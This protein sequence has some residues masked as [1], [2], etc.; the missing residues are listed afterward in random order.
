MT[1][2][3]SKPK[4]IPWAERYGPPLPPEMIEEL[5]EHWYQE[6]KEAVDE[7]M[8]MCASMVSLLNRSGHFR[9]PAVAFVVGATCAKPIRQ[10]ATYPPTS[11]Q[12]IKSAATSFR[13]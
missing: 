8:R 9:S 10:L 11:Q 2:D 1:S 13:I 5:A 6:N 4:W 3:P 7:Y 12:S